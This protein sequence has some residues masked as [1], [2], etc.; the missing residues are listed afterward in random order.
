[1]EISYTETPPDEKTIQTIIEEHGYIMEKEQK[2]PWFHTDL[3]KYREPTFGISGD[4]SSPSFIVAFFIG[5]TAGVSSCMALVG[6][7]ILSVSAKW[8]EEHIHTS[9]WRRFEPHL[10]FNIGRIAGF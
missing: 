9:K 6:G 5:L 2:L 8:N 3:N 4:F 1:L 10:Y 7:L